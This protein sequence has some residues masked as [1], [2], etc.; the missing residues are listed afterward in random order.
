M[1]FRARS[2]VAGRSAKRAPMKNAPAAS[3]D[4]L[5][6]D[7]A[8]R[9][10]F[11]WR[12]RVLFDL[13]KRTGKEFVEDKSPKEAA[14]LAYYTLFALGPLVLLLLSIVGLVYGDQ[15]ARGAVFDRFSGFLGD[16]GAQALDD[17]VAGAAERQQAGIVGTVVGTLALLVAA[18]A[19]FKHLKDA[20]NKVWEVEPKP[21]DGWKA[22]ISQ[23][24]RTNAFSFLAVIGTGLLLVAALVINSVLA[25]AAGQV[26]SAIPGSAWMWSSLS[27]LLTLGIA[28]LAFAT[29]YKLLPDAR[30][31][32]K[33]VWVGGVV[34]AVLFVV[35]L[36]LVS[37]YLGRSA[38]AHAY[39]AA[40]AVLL[41]LLFVNY[42]G[43]I[44]FFGAQFTQVFANLYGSHVQ[45]APHA[46][47]LEEDTL[48][49]QS[50]PAR[51]GM[52]E[53]DEPPPSGSRS[54]RR[55]P[56]G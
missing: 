25:A 4:P 49:R 13:M 11:S 40:G 30:V 33:D 29:L 34:T 38:F 46:R 2:Y 17:L 24:V 41:V 22:K 51:E 5:P 36:T 12:P 1:D 20:L 31:G 26:G 6:E 28:S 8:D 15:A 48:A 16:Q 47:S 52:E 56:A 55:R 14:A 32:W 44:F 53:T 39:G 10:G 37:L 27:L 43:M 50:H 3:Y 18:G 21:V 19:L 23:F 45:P 9:G 35:G 42:A 54:H 7:E